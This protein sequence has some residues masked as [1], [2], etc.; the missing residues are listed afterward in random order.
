[1][2]ESCEMKIEHRGGCSCG[3]RG[4]WRRTDAD[5]KHDKHQHCAATGHRDPDPDTSDLMPH[6][7]VRGAVLRPEYKGD[8]N[9]HPKVPSQIEPN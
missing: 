7:A 4:P 3:W 9:E 6:E 2:D 5:A 1:M 8:H